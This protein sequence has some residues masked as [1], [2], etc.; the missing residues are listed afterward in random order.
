MRTLL[1][2]WGIA[3]LHA[4]KVYTPVS[5]REVSHLSSNT[6][7]FFS[8]PR[9]R[10]TTR[11]Q[12]K[13]NA[14]FST[15]LYSLIF[16]HSF[17]FSLLIFRGLCLYVHLTILSSLSILFLVSYHK[18]IS[19]T[20]LFS[21]VF[22]T[23]LRLSITT[24]PSFDLTSYRMVILFHYLLLFPVLIPPLLPPPVPC[25]LRLPLSPGRLHHS[26]GRHVTSVSHETPKDSLMPGKNI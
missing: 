14:I 17:I 13:K 2:G 21:F 19:F 24:N 9:E 25:T 15:I 20:I 3:W 1:T 7:N 5:L 11:R 23:W 16:I 22:L 4:M 10:R 8:Q 6:R 26:P 12:R 18:F